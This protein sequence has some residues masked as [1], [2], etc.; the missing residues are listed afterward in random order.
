MEN[1]LSIN[2][3]VEMAMGLS[4][5]SL[6]AN[7]MNETSKNMTRAFNND[8][9]TAPPKYIHAIID[10]QQRGPFSL[11]EIKAMIQSGTITLDSYMWKPGMVDWQVAKEITDIRPT[12]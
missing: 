9:F 10:G 6:F 5:A 7:A 3:M 4:M 1:N 8:Q 11:G 12:S 2:N